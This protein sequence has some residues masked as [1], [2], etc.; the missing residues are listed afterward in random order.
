[1]HYFSVY[2]N[3]DLLR[4]YFDVEPREVVYRLLGSL[5]PPPLASLS[6]AAGGG[7]ASGD[8]LHRELYGPSMVILTLISLLLLQM[9]TSDHFVVGC[10]RY[11]LAESRRG[12][13]CKRGVSS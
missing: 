1:M 5:T 9:K 7:G 8:R 13:C 11:L 10:P 4:P 6:S 3:I 12:L 2:G